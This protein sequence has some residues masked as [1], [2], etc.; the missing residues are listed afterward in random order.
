MRGACTR[1]RRVAEPH[2][3]PLRSSSAVAATDRPVA[4]RTPDTAPPAAG[5]GG[6][7]SPA[8]AVVQARCGRRAP[9][10]QP[11]RRVG[12]AGT[13]SPPCGSRATD[14]AARRVRPPAA[15][16]QRADGWGG[17]THAAAAA[18][19]RACG[20][21]T[22]RRAAGTALSATAARVVAGRLGGGVASKRDT[23]GLRV[24][25][26][27]RARCDCGSGL[28]PLVERQ[29][30]TLTKRKKPRWSPPSRGRPTAL[31]SR[32]RSERHK[33]GRMQS[34]AGAQTSSG[35]VRDQ[36]RGAPPAR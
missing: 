12:A 1:R 20:G 10:H 14:A 31:A 21:A 6:P 19:G 29:M 4:A 35:G 13:A 34:S 36:S 30:H 9:P 23:Q 33:D 27:G 28:G 17:G 7:P 26:T 11:T 32:A 25:R 2:P 22:G 8:V 18:G 24:G 15:R 5:A 3:T 16:R